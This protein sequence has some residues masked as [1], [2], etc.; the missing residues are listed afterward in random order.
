MSVFLS[1][2]ILLFTS[3]YLKRIV[4]SMYTFHPIHTVQF[5]NPV[6]LYLTI[7]LKLSLSRPAGNNNSF[8]SS[9]GRGSIQCIALDTNHHSFSFEALSFCRFH[10]TILAWLF[11]LCH[12]LSLFSLLLGSSSTV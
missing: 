10:H 5:Y 12:W 2:F 6:A 8:L 7:L 9:S 11:L 1:I 3:K 4:C